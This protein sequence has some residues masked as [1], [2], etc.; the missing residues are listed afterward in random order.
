MIMRA[1]YGPEFAPFI[2]KLWHEDGKNHEEL[3]DIGWNNRKKVLALL[4]EDPKMKQEHIAKE[5]SISQAAVSLIMTKAKE[6]GIL[7]RRRR[8]FRYKKEKI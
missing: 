8:N 6:D 4:A 2:V 7:Y 3:S 5:L 1:G